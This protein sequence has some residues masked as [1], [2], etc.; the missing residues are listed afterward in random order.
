[1]GGDVAVLQHERLARAVRLG[2]ERQSGNLL[3]RINLIWRM[4]AT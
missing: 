4:A 1:M 2:N 3:E